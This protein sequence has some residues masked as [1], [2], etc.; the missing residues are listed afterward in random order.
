MP[1][2]RYAAFAARIRARERTL[3]YWI[4]QDNPTAT[5]RLAA[6]GYDYV[7][8][9]AQHGLLGR[10][11]LLAGLIATDAAGA[12]VGL[13]RVEANDPTAIGQALDAGAGGVIVPLVDDA[14]GAAA[15]VAAASY[16]PRGRRS[17]G[18]L[19]SRMRIGPA[20]AAADAV[21]VVIA[22]IETASGLANVG[23]ICATA[24]LDGVYVGTSDLRLTLGGAAPGDPAVGAEF[25]AAVRTVRE[26]AAGTGVAAGIHTASGEEA[27]RRLAEGYTFATVASDLVHLEQIAAR[28][29]AVAGGRT[30]PAP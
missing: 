16:P 19:R 8:L 2:P 27:G 24:G 28:H 5:E 9:D 11:A 17:Y 12:A 4:T 29:L 20:P 26:V 10:S 23:D 21:T 3:G 30:P 1:D 15:A 7:V 18:P 6:T 25:E 22:M 13:V 14:A